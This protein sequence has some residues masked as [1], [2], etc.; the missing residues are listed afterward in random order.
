M[1]YKK[2]YKRPSSAFSYS[3]TFITLLHFLCH[4]YISPSLSILNKTIF[5]FC[6]YFYFIC[7]FYPKVLRSFSTTS[8]GYLGLS[9]DLSSIGLTKILFFKFH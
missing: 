3:L 7:Y 1:T 4:H 9:R 6:I 8:S 5:Y 2:T